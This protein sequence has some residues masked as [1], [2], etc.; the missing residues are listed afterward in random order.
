MNDYSGI[1]DMVYVKEK[2]WLVAS[3]DGMV[4]VWDVAGIESTKYNCINII[5]GAMLDYEVKD[6]LIDMVRCFYVT[7]TGNSLICGT[8]NSK[9][10]LFDMRTPGGRLVEK[11]FVNGQPLNQNIP[12]ANMKKGLYVCDVRIRQNA[13][14]A[15]DWYGGIHEW[16]ILRSREF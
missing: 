8:Q 10:K 7:E 6:D 3:I 13:L 5:K 9:L 1:Y 4:Q 15:I 14:I 2:S 16:Q 12:H 11:Y